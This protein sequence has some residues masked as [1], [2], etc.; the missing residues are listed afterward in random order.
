[1][2]RA[3]LAP[4]RRRAQDA[5]K[6]IAKLAEERASIEAKLA[7]PKLYAGAGKAVEIALANARLA[8]IARETAAAEEAWLEAQAALEEAS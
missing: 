8:A 3:A 6:T 7:N 1:V 4:L 2:A 5:E